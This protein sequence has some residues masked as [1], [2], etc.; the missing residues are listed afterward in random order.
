MFLQT[1]NETE[2]HVFD[3]LFSFINVG[4]P[5]VT[6]RKSKNTK[7]KTP[8]SKKYSC[9]NADCNY[10]TNFK[11]DL[12]PHFQAFHLKQKRFSCK[13]CEFK[14]YQKKKVEEHQENIHRDA[15]FKIVVKIGCN[16]CEQNVEHFKHTN[17]TSRYSCNLCDY[18]SYVKHRVASHQEDI[19]NLRGQQI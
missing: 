13:F 15:E 16:L 18:K 12:R 14:S 1:E 4:T 11:H 2:K 5:N 19:H 9:V 3:Q 10:S 8:I 17:E 6:H 7:S